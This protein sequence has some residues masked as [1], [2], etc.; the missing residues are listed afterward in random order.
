M[1]DLITN[2]PRGSGKPFAVHKA[3]QF[4]A[5]CVDILDMGEKWEQFKDEPGKITRKVR[6]IFQTGEINPDTGK[7]FEVSKEFTLS[8]HPKSSLRPFLEAWR[9]EPF[10]DD[11]AAYGAL[12]NLHKLEGAW[13]FISVIHKKNA[14]G[15]RTYANIQAIMKLPAGLAKPDLPAYTRDEFW[16]KK[17]AEYAAELAGHREPVSVPATSAPDFSDFE[18]PPETEDDDDLPF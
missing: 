8:S 4:A 16:A 13:A 14:D 9:G 2:V 6:F 5:K 15:S 7:P 11:D 1:A 17:K 10:K 3:G 12:A 18:S